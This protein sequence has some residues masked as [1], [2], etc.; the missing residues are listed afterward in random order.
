MYELSICHLYLE[1][2]NLYGDRGN[3]ISAQEAGRMERH[4]RQCN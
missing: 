3:V 4:N 2:L 1:L